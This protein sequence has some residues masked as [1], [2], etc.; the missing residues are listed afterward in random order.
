MTRDNVIPM[1]RTLPTALSL[2]WDAYTLRQAV[3]HSHLVTSHLV[4]DVTENYPAALIPEDLAR[5]AAEARDA[6]TRAVALLDHFH[7]STDAYASATGQTGELVDP[8]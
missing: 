5:A 6:L 2:D 3:V 1:T 7:T 4:R 8:S